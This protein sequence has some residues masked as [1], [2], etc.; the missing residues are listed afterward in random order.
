MKKRLILIFILLS[1]VCAI[2]FIAS[3][4]FL[5]GFAGAALLPLVFAFD[6]C[7][8]IM[9][10]TLISLLVLSALQFIIKDYEKLNKAFIICILL[11]VLGF[12]N[13]KAESIFEQTNYILAQDYLKLYV[14]LIGL[15]IL[16]FILIHIS[17]KKDTRYYLF[18]VIPIIC[19][20][21]YCCIRGI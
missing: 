2:A 16:E 8:W 18:I 7:F 10:L 19:Y 21:I 12:L 9:P 3:D 6:L 5:V 20:T 13:L 4:N 1:V 11:C 15:F 17:K 14:C